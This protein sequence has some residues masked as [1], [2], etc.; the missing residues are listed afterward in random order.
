MLANSYLLYFSA[1]KVR[2]PGHV[3]R[4]VSGCDPEE[5]VAMKTWFEES[6]QFMSPK[7][8][9]LHLTPKFSEVKDE[10]G[11]VIGS[12][13]FFNKPY[14]LK[15]F[16]ENFDLIGFHGK[17]GD[18]DSDEA[19]AS[20]TFQHEDDIVILIDPDMVLMRPIT[21]D[22]SDDRE[23]LISQKR[24]KHILSREVKHGVPFAQTCKFDS[25][26]CETTLNGNIIFD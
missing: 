20:A 10:N 19:L 5:A 17:N 12:Y 13:S 1:M 6:V 14:G 3:T 11:N 16:L 26:L 23:T 9:H 15:H 4:V 25:Y 24:D 7:R 8:F 21:K 22:F 18:V 2:Q